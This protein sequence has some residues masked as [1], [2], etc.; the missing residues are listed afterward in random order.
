[1]KYEEHMGNQLDLKLVGGWNYNMLTG[2]I[3]NEPLN[4]DTSKEEEVTKKKCSYKD[5]NR[6]SPPIFEG[7][8]DLVPL[9]NWIVKVEMAFYAC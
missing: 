4:D 1:M 6:F 7:A 5:F 3:E 2:C 8:M 9:H